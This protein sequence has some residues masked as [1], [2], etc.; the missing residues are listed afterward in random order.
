MRGSPIRVETDVAMLGFLGAG[1]LVAI[2][3]ALVRAV[4]SEDEV[5]RA[6]TSAPV[7][8]WIADRD[9]C[10]VYGLDEDLIL[11]RRA[12]VDWPIAVAGRPDGGAWV[13]RSTLASPDGP[14]R[15]L[16]LD[17]EGVIR[18]ET[19]FSACAGLAVLADGSALV[20]EKSSGGEDGDRVVRCNEAGVVAIV[21]RG[22]SLTCVSASKGSIAVGD[23]HGIV[24]RVSIDPVG[25]VLAD[26]DLH[27]KILEIESDSTGA[28]FWVLTASGG[29]TIHRLDADFDVRGSI[30]AGS[31]STRI[32]S[33]VDPDR[34]WL[35]DGARSTVRRLGPRGI[36]EIERGELP[37]AGS[38]S[39]VGNSHGGLSIVN[40][41]SVLLLDPAGRTRAGLGGFAHL[42][43][44]DRVP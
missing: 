4:S 5:D 12:S 28:A 37:L 15:L 26:V 25:E 42:V 3:L 14:A 19:E 31:S 32:A 35:I 40:P 44:V 7:S 36:V 8:L 11:A 6:S 16:R 33:H 10:A 21:H 30:E 22:R 23:A 41:G 24:R 18:S 38:A 13:L 27:E 9:G 17:P 1:A 29:A 34:I 20:L 39:A 2:G 43:D